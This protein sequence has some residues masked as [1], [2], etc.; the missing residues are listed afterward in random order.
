M[1]KQLEPEE[2]LLKMADLCARSEQCE[3]DIY[4]K[5][6]L[7]GLGHNDAM[8]IIAELRNRKFIDDFR[9]ARSFARDKVRFSAWGRRKIRLALIAKKIP[10][11]IIE[12]A[13]GEID[14]QDYASALDRAAS[15][16][17]SGLN[18]SLYE[19]RLRLYKYLVSRGFESNLISNKIKELSIDQSNSE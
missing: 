18:L 16:K 8:D 13:F 3:A 11:S 5:L 7:K 6:R 15:S 1:K 10:S 2:A 9:Y 4:R 12:E 19:D 14:S 17:L